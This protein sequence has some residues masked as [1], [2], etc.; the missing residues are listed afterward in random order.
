MGES[1]ATF[2]LCAEIQFPGVQILCVLQW[3]LG[4]LVADPDAVV[5]GVAETRLLL[6]PGSSLVAVYLPLQ[7]TQNLM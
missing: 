3:C 2:W 6:S 1:T 7:V 5:V 4:A